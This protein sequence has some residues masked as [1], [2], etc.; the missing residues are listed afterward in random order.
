MALRSVHSAHADTTPWRSMWGRLGQFHNKYYTH[1]V[2]VDTLVQQSNKKAT[3]PWDSAHSVQ[4]GTIVQQDDKEAAQVDPTHSVQARTVA[5]QHDRVA[6][7]LGSWI[8]GIVDC[9]LR[10]CKRLWAC[11]Q[12]LSKIKADNRS[13]W[14]E[15]QSKP[16]QGDDKAHRQS[17]SKW[18]R[19]KANG[20]KSSLFSIS[21]GR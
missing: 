3:R 20:W 16:L 1:S 13:Q 18:K 11:W 4:A 6:A 17:K 2:Q 19:Q 9:D 10:C 8:H 14:E 15:E 5:R 21:C 12:K 7:R